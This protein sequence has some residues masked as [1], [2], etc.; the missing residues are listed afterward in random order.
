MSNARTCTEAI[1]SWRPDGREKV[2]LQP[3]CLPFGG[4]LS[5]HQEIVQSLGTA[6][7]AH[8]PSDH[9]ASGPR[10]K[11]RLRLTPTHSQRREPDDRE[12]MIET[13]LCIRL[14]FYAGSGSG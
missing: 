7:G 13:K 10:E 9:D 12:A 3:A 14:V 8:P 5:F 6:Q 4:G 11:L 2:P 1:A